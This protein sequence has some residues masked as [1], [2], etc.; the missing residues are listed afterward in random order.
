ML[1]SNPHHTPVSQIPRAIKLLV[2]LRKLKRDLCVAI[3]DWHFDAHRYFIGFYPIVLT[4][5]DFEGISRTRRKF[6][7][8]ALWHEIAKLKHIL[9]NFVGVT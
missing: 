3:P 4:Q 1:A 7:S 5:I 9:M 2:F 8:F 6:N